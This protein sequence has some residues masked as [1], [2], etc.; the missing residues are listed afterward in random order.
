ME[1]RSVTGSQR[2]ESLRSKAGPLTNGY[3]VKDIPLKAWLLC[4]VVL[5]FQC[6]PRL[7]KYLIV[8]EMYRLLGRRRRWN[9]KMEWNLRRKRGHVECSLLP[10]RDNPRKEAWGWVVYWYM[11]AFRDKLISDKEELPSTSYIQHPTRFLNRQRHT[12]RR[13]HQPQSASQ[14]PSNQHRHR[15]I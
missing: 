15:T 11:S 1:W 14:Y 4:H 2:L 8:I 5:C 6:Y 3:W 10:G 13:I 9:W 12:N 7:T